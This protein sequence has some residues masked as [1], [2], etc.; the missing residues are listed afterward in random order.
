VNTVQPI[1]ATAVDAPR[2]AG[3][4][5]PAQAAALWFVPALTMLPLSTRR[6]LVRNPLNGAAMELSSGEYAVLAA[7]EGCLPLAV[8]EARAAISLAAPA[9]HRP[10]FRELLHRCAQQGLLMALADLTGRFG[11]APAFAPPPAPEIVIRTAD[12]PQLLLRLLE[13]AVAL[14]AHAGYAYRWHVVD[15]SRREESRRANAAA[16]A[17]CG[18]LGAVHHDLAQPESLEADLCRELP[19]LGAEVRLLLA[20]ARGDE[21]TYGRPINYLLLRF[22]G[23]RVLMLDDDVM[24]DPRRPAQGRGGVEVS[25]APEEACWYESAEAAL[26]ACPALELDPFAAHARW[27]GV[28]LAQAWTQAEREPGGLRVADLPPPCGAAFAA[29]ARIL[30]TRNHVLG[31]PG[32]ARFA[33]PLLV[34]APATRRWLAAH[35]EAARYA[36]ASPA[37][38]R[39]QL[40][41]RVAPHQTLSTTT[42]TGFDNTV[43][44]PPTERRTRE[45]DV[46]LGEAARCVYP[47][48]WQAELPFALPHLRD[49][50]RQWL[51]P[52]EALVLG[53]SL[54]LI[55]HARALA[56]SIRGATA[57]DRMRSLSAC[58]LDLAA[59]PDRTLQGLLEEQAIAYAGRIRF[60]VEEQ[61]ADT[62]LP[63]AWHELLQRWLQA[64]AFALDRAAL[65]ASIVAPELVRTEAQHYGRTLAA[66]PQIWDH[67]RERFA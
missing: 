61:L 16:I 27:L 13:G 51:R 33:S 62:S 48:G 66:W 50:A 39:G 1:A 22:A 15:D 67:C 6:C 12:R 37:H 4:G 65:R 8:H 23:R 31:D 44:L 28:S 40:G 53:P 11:H 24:I 2:E 9:E 47:A 38:W 32:W 35:P 25:L 55:T 56:P 30:F 3:P 52:D 10:A 17:R 19:E 20:A 36:F 59:A 63:G 21:T 14:Q 46:L 49:A 34:L 57:A 60:S 7:C 54:L 42:L 5:L 26:S 64:P 45:A 29:D 43:L 41:L 18:A 58:L